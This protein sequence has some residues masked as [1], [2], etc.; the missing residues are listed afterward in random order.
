MAG[1][2]EGGEEKEEGIEAL[3]GV[4]WDEVMNGG[5][6]LDSSVYICFGI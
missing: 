3:R 5:W 1:W 4:T 6:G 2:W